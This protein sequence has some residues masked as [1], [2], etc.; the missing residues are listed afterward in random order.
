MLQKVI[1]FIPAIEKGGVERNAIWVSN[2]LAKRG[3]QVDVV[4]VRSE[5]GQLKKFHPLVHCVKMQYKRIPAL[6]QRLSDAF[7]IRK[8]FGKYLAGQDN[9]HTVVLAFQSAS[10]AIGVCRKHKVKVICRLSN[11]PS[12]VK[13]EKS[14]LR[15][16]SEFVKPYTYKKADQVIGNSE[17]LS[18]D[19]GKLIHKKV[20]TIYNPI[21]FTQIEQAVTEEIPEELKR[22]AADFKGRLLITVGRI[23]RQKDMQTLLK[24]YAASRAKEKS[25]LW[26]VGEGGE[27]DEIS[28]LIGQLHLEE[29]VHLLGYQSNVY[30]FMKYADLFVQTSLY[31]GCPNALIEAVAAGLPAIAT[32]CLSGPD[33][34]LLQGQ[35]GDLI[36]IGDA[37]KLAE[38]IDA[39]FDDPK[40]LQEKQ[41]FAKAKLD[42]FKNETTMERYINLLEQVLEG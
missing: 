15:K 32:D 14:K 38:R 37:A 10:V 24:G 2:E 30:K 33:E 31:E 22:E 18:E 11:H 28:Q 42:R 7:S 41:R 16:I 29:H 25:M 6:N 13:Y 4:F 3:Y 34:V 26:I 9:K 12:A 35:G 21:D 8:E 19:F 27:R 36:P 39:Y 17:R 23:T 5:E 40:E 20:I 1:I